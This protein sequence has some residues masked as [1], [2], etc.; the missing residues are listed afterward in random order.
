MLASFLL[1]SIY[2]QR[3]TTSCQ[4]APERRVRLGSLERTRSKKGNDENRMSQQPVTVRL[5][6]STRP[7][8]D[9]MKLQSSWRLGQLHPTATTAVMLSNHESARPTRAENPEARKWKCSRKRPSSGSSAR[10][11]HSSRAHYPGAYSLS[12]ETP[13]VRDSVL[14][15]A[16]D[17]PSRS[18]PQ[19]NTVAAYRAKQLSCQSTPKLRRPERRAACRSKRRKNAGVRRGS[20]CAVRLTKARCPPC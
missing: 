20:L 2:C 8:K 15:T 9:R 6:R 13:C 16:N 7:R 1:L 19:E 17:L 3:L 11:A 5:L 14:P 4:G 18:Q 10:L 12:A